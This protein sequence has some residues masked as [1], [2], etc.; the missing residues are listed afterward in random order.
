MTDKTK[1]AFRGMAPWLK[2]LAVLGFVGLGVIFVAG[3]VMII[4]NIGPWHLGRFL[5]AFYIIIAGVVVFP[6]RWI[7]RLAK[8]SK[9]CGHEDSEENLEALAVN[10]HR[11]VKFYGI[12]TIVLLAVYAVAIAGIFFV[13]PLTNGV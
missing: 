12:L 1:Q 4:L 10:L 3:V 6:V 11:L 8:Q 2:F 7:F 13:I 9:L 5:G